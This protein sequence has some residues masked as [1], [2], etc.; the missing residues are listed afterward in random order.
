M[1]ST[2][3]NRDINR[4]LAVL[5]LGLHATSEGSLSN[6]TNGTELERRPLFEMMDL[7]I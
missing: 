2:S 6:D 3:T 5:D 1:Q 4:T 7:H